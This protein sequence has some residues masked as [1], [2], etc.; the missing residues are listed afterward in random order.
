MPF[1]RWCGKFLRFENGRGGMTKPLDLSC[2]LR[3]AELKRG[4]KSG[5]IRTEQIEQTHPDDEFYNS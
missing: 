2:R 1:S 3:G 5:N 4:Q